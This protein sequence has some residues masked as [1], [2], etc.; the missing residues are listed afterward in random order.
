MAQAKKGTRRGRQD[1]TLRNVR[2]GRTREAALAVRVT[3]LE[4][5]QAELHVLL[6]AVATA[7]RA[8][9]AAV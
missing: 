3:N 7:L 6:Q 5:R 2:A 4:R 9:A 8:L 1:A